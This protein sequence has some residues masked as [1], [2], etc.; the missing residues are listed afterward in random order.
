MTLETWLHFAPRA[1]RRNLRAYPLVVQ[2]IM[3]SETLY[4]IAYK[5]CFVVLW[6]VLL[7]LSCVKASNTKMKSSYKSL[8]WVPTLNA[9]IGMLAPFWHWLINF[10]FR[11]VH[12][13]DLCLQV[14]HAMAQLPKVIKDDAC[15]SANDNENFATNWFQGHGSDDLYAIE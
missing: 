10:S 5:E 8:R 6:A 15:K 9:F 13:P 7:L 11:V 1:G 2:L 12:R 4:G 14:A 3:W